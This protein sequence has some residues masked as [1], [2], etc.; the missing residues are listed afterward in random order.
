LGWA[1]TLD[2]LD[3]AVG[4][5]GVDFA[6]PKLEEGERL[7]AAGKMGQGLERL[8][9]AVYNVDA[10]TPDY[11]TVLERIRKA[12]ETAGGGD[13]R[14]LT[15]KAEGVLNAVAA[16]RDGGLTTGMKDVTPLALGLSLVSAVVMFIAVFLP[17]VD[18]TTFA[19]VAANTLIQ[20]GNG[21][22]FIGLAAAIA[23]ASWYAYQRQAGGAG[24]LVLGAIA[25]AFAIFCGTNRSSLTLCPVGPLAGI[26]KIG[27]QR[28]SPGVGI[29]AAAVGGLLAIAG[30]WG[31]WRAEPIYEGEDDEAEAE[32]GPSTVPHSPGNLAE[33]LARVTALHEAGSLSDEEFAA[34][35]T[36][37]LG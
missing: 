25:V 11:E 2:L 36:R 6:T 33:Q 23:V 29:Y 1:P 18:S 10:S 13:S 21:W 14:R 30:G 37:L 19:R 27:C 20:E 7:I 28:A 35:K 3:I 5:C 8:E 4:R 32:P 22:V 12:A 34:A 9:V 26:V 15:R 16:K 24:V 31:I 17:R